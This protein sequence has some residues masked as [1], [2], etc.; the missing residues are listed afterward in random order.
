MTACKACNGPLTFLGALGRI[1]WLRCRRCG[2]TQE[3]PRVKPPVR[4]TNCST[5]AQFIANAFH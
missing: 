5:R 1:I 4:I 2:M 3:A